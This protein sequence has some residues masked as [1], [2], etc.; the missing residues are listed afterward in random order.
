MS[1]EMENTGQDGSAYWLECVNQFDSFD[2]FEYMSNKEKDEIVQ[3]V[4]QTNTLLGLI[5]KRI[6]TPEVCA[7][8]MAAILKMVGARVVQ[9]ASKIM[10][11]DQ[12][13]NLR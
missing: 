5:Q 2:L 7:G 3:I 9:T 6:Y 8:D 13:E 1:K 12:K 4:E 11:E 10:A